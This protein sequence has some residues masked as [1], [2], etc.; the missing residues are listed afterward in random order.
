MAAKMI[1]AA[2]LDAGSRKTRLVICVLENGRLRI[3]GCSAVE[4]RGWIK[5]KIAD[6]GAV[7]ETILTALRE[8][9]A[10]AGISLESVSRFAFWPCFGDFS[11]CL[12]HH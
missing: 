3:V 1:Y 5:G 2:G 9:E 10:S 12:L 6:Q 11:C 4:S 7:A 8:A